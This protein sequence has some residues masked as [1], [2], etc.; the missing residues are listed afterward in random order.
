[1]ALGLRHIHR[2]D[3]G[4][5]Q[6]LQHLDRREPEAPCPDH[7]DDLAR[8]HGHQLAD[9][10]IDSQA[11][12]GIGGRHRRI[13]V[14]RIHQMAGMGHEHMAAEAAGLAHADGRALGAEVVLLGQ[15]PLALAA[16]HP[17]EHD[18]PVADLDALARGVRTQGGH[19]AHDL[20]AEGQGRIQAHGRN[21]RLLWPAEVQETLPEVHVRVADAAMGDLDQHL[22][23]LRLWRRNLYLSQRLLGFDDG[24]G[25]HGG[26]SSEGY[27]RPRR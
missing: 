14:A 13:D 2:N 27:C 18:A 1:M 16:S 8:R 26:S 23:P 25:P 22:G 21:R 20:V 11:R 5:S 24:P 10:R 7:H 9:R 3:V 15:A 12:A 4:V 19:P 6:R 17:G